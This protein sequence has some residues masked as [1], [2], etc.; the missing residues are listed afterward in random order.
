[1]SVGSAQEENL[2]RSR[3]EEQEV[4]SVT[5]FLQ[6]AFGAQ[7]LSFWKRAPFSGVDRARAPGEEWQHRVG[8]PGVALEENTRLPGVPLEV[9]ILPL[10]GPKTLQIP[11]RGISSAGD[12]GTCRRQI[13]CLLLFAVRHHRCCAPHRHG[14]IFL[15]QK[16]SDTLRR[17]ITLGRGAGR[18]RS[19]WCQVL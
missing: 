9:G 6:T 16:T 7:I 17:G 3:T 18:G 13:T 8:V 5:G 12:K 4:L 19:K 10:Q 14:I 15:G 2:S 11:A 1:M